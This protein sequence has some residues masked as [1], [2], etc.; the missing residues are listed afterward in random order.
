MKTI[1][2]FLNLPSVVS[3]LYL[4]FAVCIEAAQGPSPSEIKDVLVKE[5]TQGGAIIS[6]FRVFETENLGT[7]TDP[8][9]HTRIEF[10][11]APSEQ[12]YT[13]I[14]TLG[15]TAVVRLED[16]SPMVVNAIAVSTLVNGRWDT[17]FTKVEAPRTIKGSPGSSLGKYVVGGSPEHKALL[18][19]I[20]K[21]LKAVRPK[22]SGVWGHPSP[23]TRQG[24]VRLVD[25]TG[26][27]IYIRMEIPNGEEL[28]G[29]VKVGF[30]DEATNKPYVEQIIPYS[31]TDKGFV[32]SQWRWA[33]DF[34]KVGWPLS[35]NDWKLSITPDGKLLVQSDELDGKLVPYDVTATR[36]AR[37]LKQMARRK[38]LSGTWKSRGGIAFAGDNKYIK[39]DAA[40]IRLTF[41]IP[42]TDKWVESAQVVLENATE[43]VV[44]PAVLTIADDEI[45]LEEERKGRVGRWGTGKRWHIEQDGDRMSVHTRDGKATAVL[46]R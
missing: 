26:G 17:V 1:K 43:K 34:T 29:D 33:A 30:Y 18:I 6:A 16:S 5:A 27:C 2:K 35:R 7:N 13:V 3:L 19:S 46:S 11:E 23:Y 38:L 20:E 44:L 41:I 24:K 31:Y 40:D 12:L 8:A 15:G 22:F 32:L 36:T 10:T 25:A 14:E 42:D 37:Y 21:A 4:T 28:A 9:I 39:R 45:T